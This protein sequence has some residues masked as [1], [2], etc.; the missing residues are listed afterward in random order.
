[1]PDLYKSIFSSSNKYHNSG[2][3]YLHKL[4]SNRVEKKNSFLKRPNLVRNQLGVRVPPVITLQIS[5]LVYGSFCCCVSQN[6]IFNR[7]GHLLDVP[8][9]GLMVVT[10]ERNWYKR[11]STDKQTH[12]QINRQ[13][14][15]ISMC[16]IGALS[17]NL[18]FY[19]QLIKLTT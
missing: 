15:E 10:Y 2:C 17:E 11:F 9:Q 4:A 5:Y 13:L 1:M 19:R 14:S 8:Y 3:V 7:T 6:G 18:W 12:L 16:W